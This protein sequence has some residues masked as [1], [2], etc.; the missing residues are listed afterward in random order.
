MI[1]YIDKKNHVFF[2][3]RVY[4]PRLDPGSVRGPGEADILHVDELHGG[5]TSIPAQT[6]NT[7]QHESQP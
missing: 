7:A 3:G 1:F 4:L 6:P 5:R 2:G